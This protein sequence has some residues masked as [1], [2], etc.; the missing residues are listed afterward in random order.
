[1]KMA[2]IHNVMPAIVT[3]IVISTTALLHGALIFGVEPHIAPELVGGILK[4]WDT[5]TAMVISY[6]VG[7]TA[8]SSRKTELIAKQGG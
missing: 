4:T 5:L 1:M 6:W 3:C 8:S 7:T 2:E